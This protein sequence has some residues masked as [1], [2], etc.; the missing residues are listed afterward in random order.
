MRIFKQLLLLVAGL[1]ASSL[2]LEANSGGGPGQN[3]HPAVLVSEQPQQC[4]QFHH[5]H[6]GSFH[7]GNRHFVPMGNRHFV[8]RFNR[9]FVLI[10]NRHFVPISNQHF[11]LINNRHFVPISNRQFVPI[12]N[13]Q[14]VP[15][16]NQHFVPMDN[17]HFIPI[18]QMNS[19][20]V[21]RGPGVSDQPFG[22]RQVQ[23]VRQF[24]P[25]TGLFLIRPVTSGR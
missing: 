14:F 23:F 18:H 13:R 9:N 3:P 19:F 11:V 2:Y 22:S 1:L 4:G 16:S 5:F 7:T 24:D 12:N 25:R 20:T 8:P 6:T 10:N 15:I 21:I 17:R